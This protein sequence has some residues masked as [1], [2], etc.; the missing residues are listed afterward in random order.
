MTRPALRTLTIEMLAVLASPA[1]LYWVLR[2]RAMAPVQQLDPSTE[3]AFIFHPGVLF[4][5]FGNDLSPVVV[6][7]SARVGFLVPARVTYLL[8]GAVPGFLVY[9]YLLA[10]VAIIPVY[11]LLRKLYGQWAGWVGVVVLMSSPVLVATW[12]SDYAS[13][14]A[15][16]YLVGGQAALALSFEGRRRRN[17]WLLSAAVLLS[18]SA[19]TNGVCAIVILPAVIAYLMLRVARDRPMLGRDILALAAGAASTTLLLI[20]FAELLLG[21]WDFIQVSIQAGR[22]LITPAE[23]KVDYSTSW[24]WA[25][26]DLYLLVPPTIAI[27]YFVIFSRRRGVRSSV[28]LVGIAGVLQM[29]VFAYLQFFGS[30]WVLEQPLFSCFLWGAANLMLA[31]LVAEVMKG[32]SISANS[33]GGRSSTGTRYRSTSPRRVVMMAIP[34]MLMLVVPVA[35]EATR[36]APALTWSPWGYVLS[37]VIILAAVFWR[38]ASRPGRIPRHGRIRQRDRRNRTFAAGVV[39]IIAGAMLILTAAPEVDHSPPPNTSHYQPSAEYSSVLG[40]ASSSYVEEYRAVSK[41]SSFMDPPSYPHEQLLIWTKPTE[42]FS[43]LGPIGLNGDSAFL[44]QGTYPSL[45]GTDL[46]QINA[47]HPGQVLLM[48]FNNQGFA[49]AVKALSP[50]GARVVRR[51]I[52]GNRL[53]PLHVW[54]VDLERFAARPAKAA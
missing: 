4:S 17:L 37:L 12:G 11:L 33:V 41:L 45:D 10:L 9:R 51:G 5:R 6:G 40:G 16:S 18:M 28:L 31:L 8:F 49:R 1:V 26:Y 21:R 15:I 29:V 14:A 42:W 7:D 13:S 23:I 20:V 22:E 44:L 2:L 35:Y 50:Y 25:P 54:L 36:G 27:A 52:L 47:H 53:Y 24:A 39:A 43:L 19:W 32:W 48:G 46:Y 38:M 3:T 34:A 30:L